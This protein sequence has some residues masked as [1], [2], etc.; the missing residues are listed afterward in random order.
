[1]ALDSQYL[2]HV[3]LRVLE[4]TGTSCT[5]EGKSQTKWQRGP[6]EITSLE[7]YPA[8]RGNFTAQ[9]TLQAA[10]HQG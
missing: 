4:H 5:V 1:M 9:V 10:V 7:G 3:R 2:K 6:K 8:R